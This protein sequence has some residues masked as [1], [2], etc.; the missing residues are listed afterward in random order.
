MENKELINNLIDNIV[1]GKNTD[2][3]EIFNTIVSSKLSDALEVK[4]REV[5]MAIY[6]KE[7]DEDTTEITQ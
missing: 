1:D 4:K 3:Q 5:A 7:A 2:A 6:S